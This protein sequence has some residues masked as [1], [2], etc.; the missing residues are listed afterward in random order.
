MSK[1]YNSRNYIV[2][3]D[4]SGSEST[5]REIYNSR[6]YIVLLDSASDRER[7]QGSTIVEIILSY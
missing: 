5:S 6:N 4:E 3:L 7:K 2:L 1:I